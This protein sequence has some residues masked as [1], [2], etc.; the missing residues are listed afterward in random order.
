[1]AKGPRLFKPLEYTE[2]ELKELLVG[3]LLSSEA[4]FGHK[5]QKAQSNKMYFAHSHTAWLYAQAS[6]LIKETL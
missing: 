2:E 6:R 4:E 5:A 1:M 3:W